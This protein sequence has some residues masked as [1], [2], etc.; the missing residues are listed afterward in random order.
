MDK[1][2]SNR[3]HYWEGPRAPEKDPEFEFTTRGRFGSF[4]M[5]TG[6]P[7]PFLESLLLTSAKGGRLP[8][9][10]CAG[11]TPRFMATGLETLL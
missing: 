10:F 2:N 5:G 7:G 3:F 11:G 4:A 1:R 8:L 6:P 9:M